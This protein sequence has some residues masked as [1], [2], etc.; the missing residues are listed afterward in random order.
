LKIIEKND[1]HLE[2][3]EAANKKKSKMKNQIKTSRYRQ[4]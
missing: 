2:T 3:T 1:C 4:L